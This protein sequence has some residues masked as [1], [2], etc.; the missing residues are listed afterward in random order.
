MAQYTERVLEWRGGKGRMSRTTSEGRVAQIGCGDA[1]RSQIR[2]HRQNMSQLRTS[3]GFEIGVTLAL[4]V[5]SET[6]N[7]HRD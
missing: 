6:L 4:M 7:L 3:N 5:Y 2:N 1:R